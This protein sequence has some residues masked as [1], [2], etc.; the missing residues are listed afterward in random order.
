MKFLAGEIIVRD[1]FSV[2]QTLESPQDDKK[3]QQ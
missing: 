1:A 2:L 3:T